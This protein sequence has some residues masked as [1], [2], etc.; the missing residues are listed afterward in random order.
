MMPGS[1]RLWLMWMLASLAGLGVGGP[2]GAA[3]GS[4]GD[5]VVAGYVGV[6]VGGIVT[7]LLQW[8]VLRRQ[9]AWA[10]WWILA[11]T[12]GWIVGGAVSG[13]V[14]VNNPVGWSVIGAVYGA[15]TGMALVWLLR[16]RI[17]LA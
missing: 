11:S 8:L 16:R 12:V 17:S 3:V 9:V 7:G 13:I 1:R 6:N 2:V 10:G 4:S 14:P 5:I 15:I